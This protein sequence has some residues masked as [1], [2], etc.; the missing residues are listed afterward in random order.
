[1]ELPSLKSKRLQYTAF[2][3]FVI[4]TIADVGITHIFVQEKIFSEGNPIMA[5]VLSSVGTP[6]LVSSKILAT[7]LAFVMFYYFTKWEKYEAATLSLLINGSVWIAASAWNYY[8]IT[9]LAV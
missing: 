4:G 1:M 9:Y 2:V 8:M 7:I 5:W 3:I 6:G